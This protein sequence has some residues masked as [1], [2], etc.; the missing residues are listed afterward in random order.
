[1]SDRTHQNGK[2]DVPRPKSIDEAS[3]EERWNATFG[4]TKKLN[5]KDSGSMESIQPK[6]PHFP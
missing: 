5:H 1:M 2:G 3:Y 4:K 6:T